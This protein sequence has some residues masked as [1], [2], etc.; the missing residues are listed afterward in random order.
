[1]ITDEL[2][3]RDIKEQFVD[4]WVQS[5]V[6][7][8]LVAKLDEYESVRANKGNGRAQKTKENETR[9]RETR[10]KEEEQARLKAEE[11]TKAVEERRRMEEERRINERIVF[12]E[13][14][15]LKKERWLVAVQIRHVQ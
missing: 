12:E 3:R 5:I 6:S 1:M 10:H 9:I 7:G 4:N 8:D 2:K 15:R 13:E 11:E 14:M